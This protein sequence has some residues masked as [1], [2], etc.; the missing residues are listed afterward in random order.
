MDNDK[1]DPTSS[2]N[3]S[4][5]ASKCG[6]ACNCGGADSGKKGKIIIC[7]VVAIAA[8]IVLG[9]SIMQ[10][11]DT[12]IDGDQN[13]FAAK[14]LL[15]EKASPAAKTENAK[16]TNQTNQSLWGKPLE[17]LASLNEV[18]AQKDA[19]FLYLPAKD[20]GPDENVRKKIEAAAGKAQSQGTKMSF[21]VL[22][23]SSEDYAQVTSQVHA[24][25]VLAIVKG[26]GNSVATT[27][28]SEVN[29]LQSLVTAS[30]PPGC[31]PGGCAKP[32]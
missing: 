9:N 29:L 15:A 20:Q 27:N 17:S 5:S 16:G 1:F 14:V 23:E 13:A 11:G 32:C 12:G 3:Q 24:P 28:I 19:V 18:A 4:E 21:F 22:D 26:R 10:K 31:K 2:A 30:R 6:P 8:A 25:C 7:L